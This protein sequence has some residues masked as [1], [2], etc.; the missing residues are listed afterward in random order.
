[1][2]GNQEITSLSGPAR[3]RVHTR[4]WGPQCGA[5]G[6]GAPVR[7]VFVSVPHVLTLFAQQT[8]PWLQSLALDPLQKYG[9]REYVRRPK[10]PPY[11]LSLSSAQ[12]SSWH[13]GGATSFVRCGHSIH[14]LSLLL[15]VRQ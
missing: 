4:T 10:P 12:P 1:M 7:I 6:P 3:V 8:R 14:V 9:M 11:V 15:L 2:T 13:D 5:Q